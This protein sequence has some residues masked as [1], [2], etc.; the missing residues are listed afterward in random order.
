MIPVV[1]SGGSGTRLWPLSRELYP[2]QFLP[3]NSD[4]TLFQETLG[5]L[6]KIGLSGAIVICNHESRFIVAENM[7]D[8]NYPDA[9][10]LLEPVG[11]NTAPAIAAAALF[12][13]KNKKD[14]VLLV[15]PA[16]HVIQDISLFKK[17]VKAGEKLANDGM[18]VTFGIVPTEPNTEYGYI[19]CGKK[20]NSQSSKIVSFKEKPT[21]AKA[22]KFLK[23]GNYFWN[24]GM[25]MFKASRYLEELKK[26]APKMVKSAMEAV[27]NSKKDLDFVRL[28]E[29]SFAKCD[30]I[31]IDYAV[32]EKTKDAAVV[33]LDARWCDVGSWASLW[34]ISKK[35]GNGNVCNGD[36]IAEDS[37]NNYFYS[38]NKLLTSIGVENLIVVDTKDAL[39]IAD[40][41]DGNV[42]KI[43]AR[44]KQDKRPETKIHRVVYRPW[45]HYDTICKGERDQVKRLTVK[46]EAKLSIQMHHHRAEHW[47]VVKGTAK[48]TKGDETMLV[49]ENESVYL[50]IGTRHGLENPGKIPLEIIEIQ[51]GSY[52]DEDDIVRFEDLYGRVWNHKVNTEAYTVENL[53]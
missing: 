50:P 1:L 27:D 12:V 16:D 36:V 34:N 52:L 25:F 53:Y 42:R 48:V 10:I 9:G 41:R 21:K 17:A 24:S 7:R 29:K 22:E 13:L 33:K 15:L 31:S 43:V 19:E 44:L 46:P 45:G 30:N 37:K 26:N 14:P 2:K 23:Q 4:K 8:I 11:R 35:D 20:I 49:S 3:L 39:L 51:T 38:E 32:M 6:K 47:V 40:R 28:E 5:R 18:L